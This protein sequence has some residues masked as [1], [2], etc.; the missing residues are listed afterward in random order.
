MTEAASG[1]WPLQLSWPVCA[2]PH[3]REHSQF[4]NAT[5]PE[6][7]PWS[8]DPANPG[9]C[10]FPLLPRLSTPKPWQTKHP[11]RNSW[12]ALIDEVLDAEPWLARRIQ[13]DPPRF[14]FGDGGL[15]AT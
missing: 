6:Q 8:L 2:F 7:R 5:A 12:P 4:P 1:A 13:T 10:L 3:L 14:H 11:Q 15:D 9:F